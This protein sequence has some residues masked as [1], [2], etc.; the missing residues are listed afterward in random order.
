MSD[1]HNRDIERVSPPLPEPLEEVTIDSHCHLELIA[2][3]EPD[4]PAVGVILTQAQSV[5]VDRVVQIGYDLA[6]SIWSVACANAWPGKVLAAVAL[7]PN[8]APRVKNLDEQLTQIE[9]L[10][11]SPRV[12]G[13]GETGL[14]FF[15]TEP[16]LRAKQEDSFRA[17]IEIAKRKNKA[18]I[19]HDRDSHSD[20]LRVLREAGAPAKTIFH[21]FSGDRAMAEECISAG[22]FLSF[23]GTVTFKN[24]PDLREALKITP[25]S[26][27][28]VET[29]APFLA[30]MPNRGL[31]NS[32]A[33][34]PNTL[35]FMAEVLERD[36]NELAIA[37]RENALSIFGSFN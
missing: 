12:R 9:R 1:R 4:D 25:L 35:R 6:Q 28:L 30:P 10:A 16:S 21:C 20:V 26:Q 13:V 29:D 27:M 2:K 37:T 15:R 31:L 11:A 17:H 7:H 36:V 3:G 24:A 5:G 23:S 19:I 14:D 34:I 22:Y 8:E 32:P 33:Q 18:L